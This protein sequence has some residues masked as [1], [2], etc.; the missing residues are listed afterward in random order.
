[1]YIRL[2]SIVYSFAVSLA[3][4]GFWLTA[5][6]QSR[7]P[8]IETAP[9]SLIYHLVAE[10]LTALLLFISGLA[11]LQRSS[12]GVRMHAV[13]LGMVLYTTIVSAGYFA[14]LE[15]WLFTG[16]FLG[17]TFLTVIFC[18]W[19]LFRRNE[20]RIKE[21]STQKRRRSSHRSSHHS[22]HHASQGESAGDGGVAAAPDNAG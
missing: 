11:L 20:Y 17:I 16:I 14:Q 2:A 13:S 22:S 1:M 6:Y 12:W 9:V 15:E 3:I 8:E 5:L 4:M 10:L 7:I 21:P 19:V 18:G